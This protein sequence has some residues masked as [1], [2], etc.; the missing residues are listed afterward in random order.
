MGQSAR[1]CGDRAGRRRGDADL[2]LAEGRPAEG[3]LRKSESWWLADGLGPT[4]AIRH[5]RLLR[6]GLVNRDELDD[7]KASRD[8]G[9]FEQNVVADCLPDERTADGGCH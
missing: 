7:P 3:G 4:A 1:P 6:R 2:W 9:Q 5:S 8:G